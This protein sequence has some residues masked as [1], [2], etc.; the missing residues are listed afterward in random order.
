MERPSSFAKR[1]QAELSAAWPAAGAANASGRYGQLLAL[2]DSRIQRLAPSLEVTVAD[3]GRWPTCAHEQSVFFVHVAGLYRSLPERVPPFVDFLRRSSA[4][5]FVVVYTPANIESP[6]RPWWCHLGQTSLATRAMCVDPS[7]SAA[8]R[9]RDLA[10][11]MHS[12]LTPLQAFPLTGG[13][14]Y[15]V[16]RRSHEPLMTDTAVLQNFAAS[17][18]VHRYG[19]A[20]RAPSVAPQC[21]HSVHSQLSVGIW[22]IAWTGAVLRAPHCR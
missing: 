13:R 6:H 5:W 21:T 4:C 14:A 1:V 22:R 12:T 17:M 16:A 15:A 7:H 18:A 2:N 20:P 9:A 3:A 19:L 10:K 11:E 8:L